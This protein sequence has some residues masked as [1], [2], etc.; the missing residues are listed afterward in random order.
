[1]HVTFHHFSFS[2]IKQ[3]TWKLCQFYTIFTSHIHPLPISV[4]SFYVSPSLTFLG[5]RRQGANTV[6]RDWAVIM[7]SEMRETLWSMSI[8]HS[9][10][11]VFVGGRA[12]NISWRAFTCFL[13]ALLLSAS[14]AEWDIMS[15]EQ[16]RK[17]A[18][19]FLPIF[20]IKV[21]A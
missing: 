12:R 4:Q 20:M 13:R 15:E 9:R 16:Q 18:F 11:R 21:I 7:F 17:L 19:E 6:P 10:R 3:F 1:M 8:R 2:I 14:N 5:H